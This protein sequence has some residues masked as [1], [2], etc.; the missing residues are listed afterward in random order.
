MDLFI[1]QSALQLRTNIAMDLF[2]RQ[3][4][5]QLRTNIAMDLFMR[6]SALQLRTNIAM[7]MF[8]IIIIEICRVP[9]PRHSGLQLHLF[10]F[11][12]EAGL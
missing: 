7:D 5:L 6:Q 8:I 10:F 11:F 1:R 12:F 2:I 4:A 3:S 9:V